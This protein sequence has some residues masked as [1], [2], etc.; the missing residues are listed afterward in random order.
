M[1]WLTTLLVGILCMLIG[2]GGMFLLAFPCIK[3][4]QIS[5]FEGR[6][7][8]FVMGMTLIGAIAG[9]VLSIIVARLCYSFIGTQWYVQTGGA[10]ASVI[11]ALL[12]SFV[13]VYAGVDRIPERN[14]KTILSLWEIRLPAAGTCE[15]A[16]RGEPLTWP[17]EE[18]R[19]ELVSVANHKPLGSR[20]AEFDREAFR[21][22]D[23]QWIL[24]A[25]VPIFTSKGE[26]CVNLS[27]GGRD[28]G[29]WPP[30]RPRPDAVKFQWSEWYRTN[31][32]RNQATDRAA[33]MYRFKYVWQEK[34]ASES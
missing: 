21:H 1:T 27:L 32:G 19:L 15:F 16:P 13:L 29:F 30:M 24:V 5:S 26:F 11:I 20:N 18:L 28:D 6:S 8:Y 25:S 31:K 10:M 2:G 17:E 3:W 22:E 7:G 23:G 34:P 33:I 9:F 12:V 4:Y 14:G